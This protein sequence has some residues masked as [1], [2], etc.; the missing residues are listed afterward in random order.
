M[1]LRS[2]VQLLARRVGPSSVGRGFRW[3]MI[4]PGDGP[5]IVRDESGYAL[6]L[7]VPRSAGEDPE[8]A[9]TAE[10][11]AAI[12]PGDRLIVVCMPVGNDPED[13]DP[14][15]GIHLHGPKGRGDRTPD[16]SGALAGA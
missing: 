13:N 12:R 6:S 5:A 4:E 14:L 10:Q 1:S 9:L 7:R 15:N 8:A 2:R 16:R 3:V 11:R